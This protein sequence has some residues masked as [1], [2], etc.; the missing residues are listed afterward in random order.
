METSHSFSSSN[1][2]LQFVIRVLVQVENGDDLF[3][4]QKFHTSNEKLGR[5]FFFFSL[6]F[7]VGVRGEGKSFIFCCSQCVPIK[8]TKGSHQVPKVFLNVPNNISFYPILSGNGSKFSCIQV[9]KRGEAKGSMTKDVSSLGRETCLRFHLGSAPCSK[10][11]V[12][13]QSNGSFSLFKK[14]EQIVGVP[15]H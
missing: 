12:M 8:F 3:W 13:G 15:S 11:L 10:I 9:V 7:G 5:G 4:K 1:E 2:C 14:E 6:I